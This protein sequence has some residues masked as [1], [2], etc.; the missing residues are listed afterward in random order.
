MENKNL[1]SSW[2]SNVRGAEY[3]FFK[4]VIYAVEQFKEKNNLPLTAL[5]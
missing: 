3:G 2:A 5:V 4:A 1:V